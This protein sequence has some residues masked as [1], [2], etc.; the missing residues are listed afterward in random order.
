MTHIKPESNLKCGMLQYGTVANVAMY[1]DVLHVKKGVE[2]SLILKQRLNIFY[3]NLKEVQL[4]HHFGCNTLCLQTSQRASL[5]LVHLLPFLLDFASFLQFLVPQKQAMF[6]PSMVPLAVV[7]L[8][9]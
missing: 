2:I 7:I 5:C 1:L 4:K 6:N 8:Y 9:A 3:I